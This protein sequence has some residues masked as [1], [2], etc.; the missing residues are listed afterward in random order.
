MYRL[1]LEVLNVMLFNG[2]WGLCWVRSETSPLD[3]DSCACA[4]VSVLL[5][6]SGSPLCRGGRL[7]RVLCEYVLPTH[8][9][10]RTLLKA[11]S[12]TVLYW[13]CC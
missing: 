8:V 1:K 5:P 6:P 2:S 3:V 4:S 9:R 11:W 13:N 10:P 12:F 7:D